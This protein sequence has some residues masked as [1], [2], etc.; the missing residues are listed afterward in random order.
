[1]HISLRDTKV[2]I[3]KKGHTFFGP[4]YPR[5]DFPLTFRN[6]EPRI[7]H[8]PYSVCYKSHIYLFGKR[9]KTGILPRNLKG[10]ADH[11][12]LRCW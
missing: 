3:I 6:F 8:N 7:Q 12:A 2:L 11:I 9:E 4:F 1:M 5:V 10:L